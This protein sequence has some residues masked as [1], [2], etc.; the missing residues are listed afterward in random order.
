M[1]LSTR[2]LR[3]SHGYLHWNPEYGTRIL[4]PT[5]SNMWET[6]SYEQRNIGI[7][8]MEFAVG[9]P[10]VRPCFATEIRGPARPTSGKKPYPP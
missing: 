9:N 6:G 4:E 10:A 1:V 3:F 2:R 8:S 5:E 7:G